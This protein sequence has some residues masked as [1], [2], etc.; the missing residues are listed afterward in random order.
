MQFS[1]PKQIE[2]YIRKE[3]QKEEFFKRI[4]DVTDAEFTEEE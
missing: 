4:K 3:I 1:I 2:L